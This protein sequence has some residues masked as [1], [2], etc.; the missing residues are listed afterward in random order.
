MFSVM[1]YFFS[2]RL[3]EKHVKEKQTQHWK[4][5]IAVQDNLKS[6]LNKVLFLFFNY[7]K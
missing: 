6:V 7:S 1:I 5:Y 2:F 3:Q 4:A